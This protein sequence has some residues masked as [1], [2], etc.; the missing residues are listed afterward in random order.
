MQFFHCFGGKGYNNNHI[1]VHTRFTTIPVASDWALRVSVRVFAEIMDTEISSI[2]WDEIVNCQ[3][4]M[5]CA[6]R[7]SRLFRIFKLS[8]NK[9]QS[10]IKWPG[11]SAEQ[12][13]WVWSKYSKFQADK[14]QGCS[15][16][17]FHTDCFQCWF[18]CLLHSLISSV[19]QLNLCTSSWTSVPKVLGLLTLSF[20]W[21]FLQY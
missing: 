6:C 12:D 14:R 21:V 11:S 1:G 8:E 2:K 5:L 13:F 9:S 10:L 15:A 18:F 17:H 7:T 3:L 20:E 4:V 19:K 16:L